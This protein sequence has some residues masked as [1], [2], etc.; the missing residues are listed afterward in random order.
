MPG[1]PSDQPESLLAE[2]APGGGHGAARDLEAPGVYAVSD[3]HGHLT[4]L[5]AALAGAGLIDT[6][7]RWTGGRATVWFLGDFTD[8]GPDGIGVIDRIRDLATQAEA[9]GGSVGA[10]LGNHELLLLGTR[11]FDDQPVPITYPERS[12][13][14][15]WTLNG[16]Q[17]SDLDR[18][19]DEHAAWLSGLSVAAR[20][21]EHL[22]LHSDTT[23]YLS[24]GD[25]VEEINAAVAAVLA[26]DEIDDWWLCF[27]RLTARHEFRDPAGEEIV[28]D[29]LARLGG[30]QVV[31][32]H[33]TIPAHL[34]VDPASVTE[35][36]RYAGGKA[37]AIDGGVYLGGPC[38]IARLT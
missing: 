7:G 10:L 32:G 27:R 31:H 3:I 35:P 21:G 30:R 24:Y 26:G 18:C 37:L 6:G 38:L 19:T 1:T 23:S 9:A 28:D 20:V 12:F 34:G 2:P 17:Q 14:M 4:E 5:D 36:F 15:V 33:S 25:S 22:L 11:T 29:L 13:R 8:R 16:G